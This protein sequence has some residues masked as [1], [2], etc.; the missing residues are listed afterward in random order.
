MI[1]I[2]VLYCTNK[3]EKW[4]QELR[5]AKEEEEKE[6]E[7]RITDGQSI[8]KERFRDWDNFKYW[9][10]G[11][12]KNCKWVN[13]VFLVVSRKSQVPRW[14]KK[15]HKKLKIVY[16]SDFIPKEL[17]PTFNSNTIQFF[18]S[19]IDELGEK[20]LV[21]D[22]DC[23]FIDKIDK[24]LFFKNGLPI[25]DCDTRDFIIHDESGYDSTF[26][27]TINNNAKFLSR[28]VNYLYYP[29]HFMKNRL[30]SY[31][32]Q[33]LKEHY[34]EFYDSLAVSRFRHPK[35]YTTWLIDDLFRLNGVCINGNPY[36]KT[37]YLQI[38]DNMDF[39]FC[40]GKNMICL[41]DTV[42]VKNFELCKNRV[43]KYLN[44]LFPDKSSFEI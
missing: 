3:D 27:A 29:D 43:N 9:F 36:Q 26:I 6:K 32:K 22:D 34:K 14:L 25:K 44:R 12:E 5:K 30:K 41:N 28:Y 35:N 4:I 33:L 16:H 1:D 40:E 31:E 17:L 8:G 38:R 37:Q 10:R 21:S 11:V 24:D 2:V 7:L 19:N 23:F 13:N 39:S 42:S 18:L 20:F 15:D